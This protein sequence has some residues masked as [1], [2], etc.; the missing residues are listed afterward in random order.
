MRTVS[1]VIPAYNEQ[2]NIP[3]TI[4]AIP[5]ERLRA[6]GFGVE[7]LVIDNGSTD[8]TRQVARSHG[9]KVIVQPV[10]GYGNAYKV[11]FANCAGDVIATGDADLTYPFEILPDALRKLDR[12]GLDFITTNRLG[13]LRRDAMTKS[14]VWGNHALSFVTRTLFDV[15]FADSQSGMWIFRRHVLRKLRLRSGGMAF[16]Q[17]L[18]VE[19]YRRGFR[20][21]EMPISYAPRGGETKNRTI[22]DGIGN[23]SQLIAARMRPAAKAVASLVDAADGPTVAVVATATVAMA[24]T[25]AASAGGGARGRH[26]QPAPAA[27]GSSS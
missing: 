11:G 9:A 19:A 24:A 27:A 25:M 8:R 17:E 26:P 10:K 18:K 23:L 15:P 14:H 6:A 13:A 20:C 22:V 16:S 21:A 4:A 5:V 1:V 12:E 3:Q 7:V 2:E